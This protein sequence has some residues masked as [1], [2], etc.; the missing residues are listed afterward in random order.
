VSRVMGHFIKHPTSRVKIAYE[1]LLLGIFIL[2]PVLVQNRAFLTV[3][4]MCF[5]YAYLALSWNLIGGY[6]GQLSLAHGAFFGIGAYGTGILFTKFG[7]TPWIGLLV[8][9]V[10]SGIFAY[11]I[12]K[13]AF[14]FRVKGFYFLLVTLAV[15]EIFHEITKDLQFI[16]GARGLWLP[17]KLGWVYFQFRGKVEYYYI[18][19]GLMIIAITISYLIEKSKLGYYLI[20]IREDEDAAEASGVNSNVCKTWALTLSGFLTAIGGAYYI[21]LF[22]FIDPSSGFSLGLNIDLM[23]MTIIGGIGTIKGPVLGAFFFVVISELLRFVPVESQ[24]LVATTRIF[25]GLALVGTSIYLPEG[26]VSLRHT[27]LRHFLSKSQN[28]EA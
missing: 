16:G 3:C 6:G 13:A 20:A 15:T 14:R 22:Y 17:A 28:A 11:V 10:V 12:G 21:Q 24:P 26:L 2:I 8:S 27:N 7:L 25:F 18:A 19:F 9:A 23:L 4:L 5:F 1:L